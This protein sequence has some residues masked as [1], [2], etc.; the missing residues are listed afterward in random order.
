VTTYSIQGKYTTSTDQWDNIISVGLLAVMLLIYAG[1]IFIP[2]LINEK[3]F[4]K[5]P[6]P[7]I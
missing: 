3:K 6:Q 2:A 1:V 4:K 7:A 5:H